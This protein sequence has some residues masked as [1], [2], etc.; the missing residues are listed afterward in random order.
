[1]SRPHCEYQRSR[2]R[3]G[4]PSAEPANVCFSVNIHP[5]H[6]N[7]GRPVACG[8]W[9]NPEFPY[10]WARACPLLHPVAPSLPPPRGRTEVLPASVYPLRVPQGTRRAGPRASY[11]RA[12]LLPERASAA[13]RV[14]PASDPRRTMTPVGEA[15][16]G[17]V[18]DGYGVTTRVP[19]RVA[20]PG[21]ARRPLGY[22]PRKSPAP[23]RVARE[24]EEAFR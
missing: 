11:A 16:A 4:G 24:E 18:S 3:G 15:P 13:R 19:G 23:S 22:R 1:M 5:P 14:R 17:R 8:I 21:K 20:S 2:A 10:P 6:E 7:L 9:G 12:F